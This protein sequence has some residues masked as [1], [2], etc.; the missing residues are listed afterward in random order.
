MKSPG[1]DYQA[2]E[3]ERVG[4]QIDGAFTGGTAYAAL[5]DMSEV[6]TGG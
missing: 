4:I 2:I 3:T 5:F 1:E 6:S